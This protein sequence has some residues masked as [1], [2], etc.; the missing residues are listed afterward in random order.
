MVQRRPSVAKR[1]MANTT[2][3]CACLPMFAV[4]EWALGKVEPQVVSKKRKGPATTDTLSNDSAK[5]D[6]PHKTQRTRHRTKGSSLAAAED[7]PAARVVAEETRERKKAPDP[8]LTALQTKMA[9]K[10][11]GARFRMINEM[12]YTTSSS[13][14]ASMFQT[15]PDVYSDYHAGFR[16]QVQTW[17]ENPTDFIIRNLIQRVNTP[18]EAHGLPSK[19][20]I[21]TVADLGCGDARISTKFSSRKNVRFY[22]FDFLPSRD[23]VA[24]DISNLPLKSSSV[25]IAIFCLSLMGTNYS[26]FLGEAIRVVRPNGEVWIAEIRSRFTEKMIEDFVGWLSRSG[27]QLKNMNRDNTMF[28]YFEFKKQDGSSRDVLLDGNPELP[29]LKACKYKKR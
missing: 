2:R 28:V 12:L 10:L 17:P 7:G 13:E 27:L 8:M 15:Q 14:A 4:D 6:K 5:R 26:D 29:K 1:H 18:K 19:K 21:C 20:G 16:Q 11:S 22:N 23:V 25:D 3:A 24:A 9:A